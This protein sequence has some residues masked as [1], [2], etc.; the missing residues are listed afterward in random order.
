MGF[1]AND[2]IALNRQWQLIG[3]VRWDR[4]D[5]Q[6]SNTIS[7]SK[8]P[9]Y[10]ASQTVNFTSV[11]AGV[12]YQPNDVQS[13]YASYGTSFNPSLEQLTLSAGLQNVAP[14]KSRSYEIGTKWDLNEGKLSLTGALFNIDKTNARSQIT[15]GVYQLDGNVRV[16]GVELG[17]AG[18]L[19]SQWQ[20][21]AGYTHLNPVV[22]KASVLDGSQGK[23]LANTPRDSATLWSTYNIT[24]EWE[25]GGGFTAMAKRFASNTNVVTAPGYTRWDATVAYHQPTYD[26]RFNLLNLTNKQYIDTLIPSDGGRSVPAAGRTGLLTVAYRF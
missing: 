11:R 20:I 25:A 17:I 4:F 1:Y 26:V 15:T 18:K 16:N 8:P 12:I 3:G 6:L 24:K 14:E 7:T 22:V 2:T 23:D 5:A 19:T 9:L 21:I 10:S 13:Y